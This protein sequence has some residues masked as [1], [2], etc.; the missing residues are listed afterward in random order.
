MVFNTTKTILK[1]Q[2]LIKDLVVS[3]DP[4]P[5]TPPRKGS[6]RRTTRKEAPGAFNGIAI[7][8]KSKNHANVSVIVGE[9]P[10]LEI[11]IDDDLQEIIE[12][13][14]KNSKLYIR[15]KVKYEAKDGLKIRIST[16][17]LST[18]EIE[19]AVA[20]DVKNYQHDDFS[21]NMAGSIRLKVNGTTKNATVVSNGSASEID[22]S[23]LK[24][25]KMKMMLNGNGNARV[26]ST[27]KLQVTINGTGNVRYQGNPAQVNKTI[28]GVGFVSPEN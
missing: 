10:G 16:Q 3:M 11:E 19:G 12:V 5:D 18:V 4:D 2:S 20:M 22:L 26:N 13:E 1:I 21:A 6:G 7:E 9:Q 8:S 15:S 25:E 23:G 17:S 28:N 24:A 14:N 27:E